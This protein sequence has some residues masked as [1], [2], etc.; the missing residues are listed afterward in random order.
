[1]E[2]ILIKKQ[3]SE[4]EVRNVE[5]EL[6]IK[7]PDDYCRLIGP[8][9]GGALRNGYI[10]IKRIGKIPY[11]RNVALNKESK[12]SIFKLYSPDSDLDKRYYPFGSVGNG[13]YFCIDL[14]RNEIVLWKHES[15]TVVF[16]CKSFTQFLSLINE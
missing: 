3:M 8:I 15:N 5:K 2:W 9:N 14:K 6:G 13:D 1:M 11:S 16:V 10:E 4:K 12:G 7:L